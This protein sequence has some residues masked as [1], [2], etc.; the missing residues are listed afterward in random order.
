MDND[1]VL[2]TCCYGFVDEVLGCLAGETRTVHVLGAIQF[3]LSNAIAKKKNIVN[4]A[5]ASER[6]AQFLGMVKLLE[7]DVDEL[8]L[9]AEFEAAA[10]AHDLELDPGESQ[11]LAVLVRRS[12]TLLLTGDKRA[13]RA[14]EPVVTASGHVQQAERRVA[15]L[16]QIVMTIVARHG[17]EMVHQ[18]VCQ[19]AAVDKS[20]SIRFSCASGNCNP[21]SICDG[22]SSYIGSIRRDAPRALVDTD[23]LSSVIP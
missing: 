9:A 19:E 21:Q 11:L 10:Q 14:I 18:R 16:E 7:P 12:A 13:I 4:K 17:A 2:K 8:L 6:L 1:V 5:I 23:D 15:C 22:L 3:V 20:L